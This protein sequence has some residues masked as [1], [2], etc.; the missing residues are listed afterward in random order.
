M[1]G[2]I[3]GKYRGEYL[4]V[5][6]QQFILLAAPTGSGKGVAL[7][8]PNLLNYTDS[9]VVFDLKL[10]N[11]RLTS[12]F[13]A[14]HGQQVFLFAPFAED[15]RTHRWNML[16]AVSRDPRRRV[17][18]ILAIGQVFYP[19]DCDPRE[20]FWND[21]ARNLFLAFVLYLIESPTLPCTMGEVFRQSSGK[22]KSLKDH[23]Q[24]AILA[25]ASSKTPLSEDCVDAFNRFLS[26]PENTLG[27]IIS[28]FNAPLLVF[29][30]PLIDAATCTSDFDL[31]HLRRQRISLYVGVEPSRLADAALLVNM[32]F[33][34]II[35][36]NTRELPENNPDLRHQCLLILDEFA[37]LGKIG[38]IAKA[39]PYIRGYN[40][41]LL[42]IVQ[43]ISQLEAI[44][45]A[46][47]TRT[48]VTN[49]GVQI[50]FPPR[51]QKD[52]KE[53]SEMLGYLTVK[54]ISTGVNRPRS[55]GQLGSSS[56]N[57]TDQRRALMLP[58]ELKEMPQTQQ[59][60]VMENTRPILC[61]KAR[62]YED[63][64][65]IE[66]LKEVSSCLAMLDRRPN[67]PKGL[68]PRLGLGRER[69]VQP[70]EAQLKHAAFVL[71]ELSAQVPVLDIA[72]HKA[73]VEQKIRPLRE[74]EKLDLSLLA[75]DVQA[76][77]R[78][79]D[80]EAPT[81]QETEAVVEA[82][83]SQLGSFAAI[84]TADV[85][86]PPQPDAGNEI[87]QGDSSLHAVSATRQAPSRATQAIARPPP[88][89]T[90]DLSVLDQ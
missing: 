31:R 82:I 72:L 11:F 6:G 74:E 22:G 55:F 38:I 53:Y 25:R 64:Q 81:E 67:K 50:L 68:L 28:T 73:K 41:R 56:E 7:V 65:F 45:G 80:P 5:D 87:S 69:A 1:S 49:H 58:Q 35:S 21:N 42:T 37:A 23:I 2:V 17:G 71:E 24:G 48:L 70:T 4:I 57:A 44:Y 14:R 62:Y 19:G 40:L 88:A 90:I 43:S 34:Q 89:G 46:G 77:P 79:A 30:N 20:K 66:R 18:D 27:N 3:V 61:D 78:F 51:E 60:I 84:D 36:L 86:E 83:F 29:A 16:D 32:L 54:S 75:I 76:V 52:A 85:F 47:D 33:S 9:V 10:E 59:I 12:A 13:R 63:P 15:R 8:V 26:A 39:N